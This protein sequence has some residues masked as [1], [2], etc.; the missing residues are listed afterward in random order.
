MIDF[1]KTYTIKIITFLLIVIIIPPPFNTWEKLIL[2]SLSTTIIFFS[3][4]LQKENHNKFLFIFIFIFFFILQNLFSNNR[5]IVNHIVLPTSFTKDF[6]YIKKTFPEDFEKILKKELTKL[7]NQ[8]RLLKNIQQP[9]SSEKSTLFKKYAF[10]S[11]NLWTRFEEGKLV[12]IRKNMNFWDFGPSALNDT[13][14]NFG[15]PQK[16]KL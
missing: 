11:E 10:Q 15:D 13:N 14:L 2:L 9:G 5:V 7:E 8:E 1:S 16:K 6:D 4:I 3:N 12:F